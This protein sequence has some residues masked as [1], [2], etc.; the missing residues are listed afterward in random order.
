MLVFVRWLTLTLTASERIQEDALETI[1][2]NNDF[3]TII[4][5]HNSNIMVI[6]PVRGFVPGSR[7]QI[8]TDVEVNIGNY[9]C[10]RF[11]ILPEAAGQGQY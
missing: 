8:L 7:I 4:I 10:S 11:S 9:W 6:Q 5:M 3:I 2:L 1:Q